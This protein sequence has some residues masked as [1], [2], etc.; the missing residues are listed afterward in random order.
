MSSSGLGNCAQRMARRAPDR[1]RSGAWDNF[2]FSC[3][4]HWPDV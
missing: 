3:R 1:H 4:S 2:Q